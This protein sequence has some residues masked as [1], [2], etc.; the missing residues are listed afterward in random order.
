MSP[1]P[2]PDVPAHAATDRCVANW[3]F[4][5]LASGIVLVLLTS[6]PSA[7]YLRKKD[8]IIGLDQPSMG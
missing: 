7:A 1:S 3:V 5:S 4:V 6:E 2:T 8:E